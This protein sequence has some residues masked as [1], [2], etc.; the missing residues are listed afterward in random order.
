MRDA[1]SIPG[2][3]VYKELSNFGSGSIL[4]KPI[5]RVTAVLGY[6]VTRVTGTTLILNPIAPTGPL[7]FNYY[8]PS[9]SLAIRISNKVT[10]KTA[11]NFY[12]YNENS[13]PGP[14]LPRDF[15]GNVFTVSL[16]YSM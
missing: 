8:L 2:P 10:Y 16:R 14:T 13:D 6:T 4:L 5:R 15:R 1:I 12:D 7:N 11:W 9:A 3:S